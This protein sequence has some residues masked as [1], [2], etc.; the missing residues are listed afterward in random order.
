MMPNAP[1]YA[2]PTE[3]VSNKYQDKYV[4]DEDIVP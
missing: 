3:S 1:R 4:D 2:S